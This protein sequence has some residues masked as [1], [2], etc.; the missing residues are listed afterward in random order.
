LQA[1]IQDTTDGIPFRGHS[2]Y[3]ATAA[4]NIDMLARTIAAAETVMATNQADSASGS[5]CQLAYTVGTT[6]TTTLGWQY[7]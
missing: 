5:F 2:N 3:G 4:E 7:P 1:F 6:G